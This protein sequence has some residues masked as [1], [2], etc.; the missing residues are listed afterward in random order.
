MQFLAL[1]ALF[2]CALHTL[3]SLLQD[4]LAKSINRTSER[5]EHKVRFPIA[6]LCNFALAKIKEAESHFCDLLPIAKKVLQVFE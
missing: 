6:K 2:L 5:S 4:N 1:L 3:Q